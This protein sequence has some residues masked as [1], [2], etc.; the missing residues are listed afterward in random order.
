MVNRMKE[1]L[2]QGNAVFGVSIMIPSVQIVEMVGKLG[3]DWVLIDCEHG[4]MS[5]ETVEL[6]AMAAQASGLIPIVR[7]PKNDAETILQY[8]DRGVMGIQAPHVST[9]TEARAVVDAVKYHP[10]GTRS[11]AV[12]TRA[13]NYGFNLT[14]SEYTQQANRE[15]LVCVQI[16]DKDALAN[17]TEIAG[18]EGIDVLF[19]GP[20]D[21][22]QSLGHPGN[23]EHPVVREAMQNAFRTINKSPKAAG[24]AGNIEL[25]AMRLEQGVTY[26]YIHLTTLLARGCSEFFRAA[27]K[28]S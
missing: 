17:I 5:L 20:S 21:L 19:V 23:S 18:V 10:L 22:S 8:M 26:Y 1:Q 9:A 14:L 12:G 16:E 2:N 4:S 15:I 24:T 28:K 27:Q 6:M 13:A 7:P 3:F 25:T 11:L